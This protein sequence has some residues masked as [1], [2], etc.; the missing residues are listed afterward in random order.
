MRYIDDNSKIGFDIDDVICDMLPVIRQFL[1][2]YFS[3]EVEIPTSWNYKIPGV[4]PEEITE[5]WVG[6][7]PSLIT[8]CKPL[9]NNIGALTWFS[10]HFGELQFITARHDECK[11]ATEKWLDRWLFGCNYRVYYTSNQC[12]IQTIK[13]LNLSIYVDDRYKTINDVAPIVDLA[14]LIDKPWNRNRAPKCRN[15]L[16]LKNLHDLIMYLEM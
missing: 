8:K 14:I 16:R 9:D 12:K 6:N 5:A 13:D 2:D 10:E 3:C 7:L 11:Q 15:T 1:S 4:T